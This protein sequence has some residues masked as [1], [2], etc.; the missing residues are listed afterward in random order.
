M[1]ELRVLL[2]KAS[3]TKVDLLLIEETM[4]T[5]EQ[6]RAYA[7]EY[8]LLATKADISIRR[9]TLLMNISRSWKS[10]ANQLDRLSDLTKAET[11]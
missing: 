5:A 3:I 4:Q 9:A 6:C 7:A 8:Q 1:E 11:K 2:F 10:L